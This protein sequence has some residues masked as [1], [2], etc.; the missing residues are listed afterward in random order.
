MRFVP[1]VLHFMQRCVSPVFPKW[2][3]VLTSGKSCDAESEHLSN[4]AEQLHAMRL[5]ESGILD[6]LIDSVIHT[7][8]SCGATLH[9]TSDISRN[10]NHT[11][12]GTKQQKLPPR[13]LCSVLLLLQKTV[14]TV[15]DRSRLLHLAEGI[16]SFV[17]LQ[18]QQLLQRSSTT[19]SERSQSA[20]NN[21]TSS[22]DSQGML[23]RWQ[24]QRLH[25]ALRCLTAIASVTIKDRRT[26]AAVLA[27]DAFGKY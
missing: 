6:G 7:L 9:K 25:A 14:K 13:V 15:Q 1:Q 19:T 4:I 16:S 24:T 12:S 18:L 8:S 27:A 2:N 3:L 11:W 10:N 22:C 23:G 20:R 26:L 17:R 5:Y 21:S